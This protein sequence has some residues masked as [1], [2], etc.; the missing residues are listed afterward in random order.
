MVSKR[1]IRIYFRKYYLFIVLI[2]IVTIYLLAGIQTKHELIYP[3]P[4]DM[5]R[6]SFNH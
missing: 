5:I 2:F 1:H 3:I 6:D 4:N